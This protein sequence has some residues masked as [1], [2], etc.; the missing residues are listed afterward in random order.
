MSIFKAVAALV[1]LTLLAGCKDVQT[2]NGSKAKKT[3]LQIIS[4]NSL[5]RT[6]K[7]AQKELQRT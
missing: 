1:V 2:C 5:P 4:E 3:V 7:L 6:S